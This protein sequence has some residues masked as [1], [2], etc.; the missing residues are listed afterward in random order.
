MRKVT[1]WR[2]FFF[3]FGMMV[4]SL[5]ITM[6]IKGKTLGVSPWDVLHIG[7]YEKVGLTIGMW[8][9]L[10][11]FIIILSTSLIL[12][13]WPKVGT[14]LNMLLIGTF[15]DFFNWI[16][17]DVSQFPLQVAYFIMGLFIL[18][19]GCGMY[20]AP[21]IGAGPRD[22]LMIILVEK[23]GLSIKMARTLIE[24]I[25]GLAGWAL[26]GPVG[27]GTI[28]LAFGS[29]YVVQFSLYYCRRLLMRCIGEMKGIKPFLN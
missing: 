29:G 3:L 9:I 13:A 12:K 28:I 20:I 23:V 15:I 11:G 16:L 27:I 21:N 26:G 10:T 2:W 18:G 17:P 5:G 24:V 6:T 25:V 8:T 7:L 4:M 1:K 22:S 19:F 14:W